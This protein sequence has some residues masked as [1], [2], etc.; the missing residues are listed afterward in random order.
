MMGV[1][2]RGRFVPSDLPKN[3]HGEYVDDRGGNPH[4]IHT[5]IPGPRRPAGVVTNWCGSDRRPGGAV[6]DQGSRPTASDDQRSHT[7]PTPSIRH[8]RAPA[9]VCA[10]VHGTCTS[11]MRLKVISPPCYMTALTS[12]ASG[13]RP[14]S[15]LEPNVETHGRFC[16]P[17]TASRKASQ[18]RTE[19]P[20][21]G[22]RLI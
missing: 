7:P 22:S 9:F 16:L 14:D 10:A 19:G 12:G 1:G 20:W 6:P 11:Y 18:Q 5:L 21:D 15:M 17:L 4:E 3:I 8:H 13:E 2:E